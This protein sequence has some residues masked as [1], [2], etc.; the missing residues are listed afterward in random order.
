[1]STST[2]KYR[3]R[4]LAPTAGRSSPVITATDR[5]GRAARMVLSAFSRPRSAP[6]PN[7]RHRVCA[8]AFIC[9]FSCWL[10]VGW[11]SSTQ[12]GMSLSKKAFSRIWLPV[13]WKLAGADLLWKAP[14]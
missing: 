5:G 4:P 2:M 13:S 10:V 8:V 3:A 1:M 6:S 9:R 7:A 11:K 14:K 12:I